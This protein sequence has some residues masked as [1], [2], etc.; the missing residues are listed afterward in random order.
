[1][2]ELKLDQCEETTRNQSP[3]ETQASIPSVDPCE[4]IV[5]NVSETI[6]ISKNSKICEVKADFRV[7]KQRSVRIWG[8]V[9]DCNENPVKCALVKLVKQVC[10]CGKVDYVGVAHTVT[11]CKGFYQFDVCVPEAIEKYKV[12]VSKPAH[13]LEIIKLTEC[14]PC[15]KDKCL[16]IK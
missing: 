3:E 4:Y 2:E 12:I 11:D 16:C 10:R 8:Q 9:K 13:G 6:E 5:G 7:N 15:G 1:M 14:A